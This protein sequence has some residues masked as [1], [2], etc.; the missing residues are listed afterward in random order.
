[1]TLEFASFRPSLSSLLIITLSHCC[2]Y[3]PKTPGQKT[4]ILAAAA[5][6]AQ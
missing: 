1:M 3:F 4:T 5:A 6:A 2:D